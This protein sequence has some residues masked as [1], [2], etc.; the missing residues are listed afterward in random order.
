[1]SARLANALRAVLPLVPFDGNH[2][3]ETRKGPQLKEARAAL[4]EW[5]A[6]QAHSPGAWRA[7][8]Y[9]ASTAN[10]LEAGACIMLGDDTVLDLPFSP[11]YPEATQRA[12]ARRIVACVNACARIATEALEGATLAPIEGEAPTF[13][14]VREDAP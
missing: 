8:D 9:A 3:D 1:M 10:G 4:A 7:S 5:E 11:A 13:E 6:T 2:D 14:L 12:K